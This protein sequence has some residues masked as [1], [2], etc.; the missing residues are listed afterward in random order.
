MTSSLLS[1][2]ASPTKPMLLITLLN[3]APKVVKEL[4]G[5]FF[6]YILF[7][8]YRIEQSVDNSLGGFVFHA[9]NL[10]A[11]RLGGNDSVVGGLQLIHAVEVYPIWEQALP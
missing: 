4:Y 9:V 11:L 8:Y 6:R 10:N 2:S 5:V 3:T 1:S 7:L